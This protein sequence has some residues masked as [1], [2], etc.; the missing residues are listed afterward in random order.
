MEVAREEV[1]PNLAQG[2]VSAW[3]V[4]AD[5]HIVGDVLQP[6]GPVIR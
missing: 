5:Y 3:E 4:S 2:F 6:Q 1:H